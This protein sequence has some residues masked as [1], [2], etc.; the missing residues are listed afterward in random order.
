MRRHP[1]LWTSHDTSIAPYRRSHL[2]IRWLGRG[3]SLGLF[4]YLLAASRIERLVLFTSSHFELNSLP[5]ILLFLG[6]LIALFQ[7]VQFPFQWLHYRTELKFQLSKQKFIG[8]FSDVAKAT[9][10]GIALG[11]PLLTLVIIFYQRLGAHWWWCVAVAS[12]LFS[13]LLA[14]LAPVFLIPIFYKL[15]PLEDSPLK[16][17]LFELCKEFGVSVKDIY[18]LGLGE[19]TEKGNAAFVGLGRTKR[20]ILGDTLYQKFSPEEVEAVFAHELGHQVHGDLWKG[21]VLSSAL[22]F[23][24]FYLADGALHEIVPMSLTIAGSQGIQLAVFFF[25]YGVLSLPLGILEVLFSRSR[26]RGADRF[27]AVNTRLSKPLAAAL[28]RL[29]I[30]NKGQFLPHSII[31]FF[32]Y[33]HPAPWRRIQKLRGT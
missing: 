12:I 19:K 25:C 27:A 31:E 1:E 17:R 14:Q 5:Q 22:L 33:S 6:I 28:E 3:V 15:A 16:K 11:G 4:L 9:L 2:I 10:L 32:T 24:T 13:V 20:I 8:W 7:I 30:Q 29:T 26:E 23:L 21:M 18:H